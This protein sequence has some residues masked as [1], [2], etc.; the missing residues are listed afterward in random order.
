MITIQGEDI[1]IPD[2][3]GVGPEMKELG[4]RWDGRQNAWK[5]AAT[6]MNAQAVNELAIDQ[7]IAVPLKVPEVVTDTRLYDYQRDAANRLAAAPHGALACL[8]PGLGKTVVA[9]TAADA[10]YPTDQI[11]VVTLASLL[12]TWEREV[13]KWSTDPRVYVMTGKV[14]FDAATNARW[15]ICSWDKLVREAKTWGKGWRLFILDESVLTKSRSSKRFKTLAKLR[16]DID[17]VWL[18][19][20]SPT[21]RHSDDLWAQLNIIWPRAFPS[22]WRFAERYCVVE[23][24]PWARVVSGD[25][26]GRNAMEE[27]SDLVMV[28]NQEDV[29]DLPE[30]LYEPPLEVILTGPQHKAYREMEKTFITELSNGT[31]V[32]AQNEIARLMQLQ[33][34]ASFWDGHSAKR[35]A[36]LD[37]IDGYKPPFLIWTHWRETA[38]E[39]EYALLAHGLDAVAV[40]GDTKDKDARIEAYKAGGHDALVLS[41]GVGKFGHTLTNT[42][43]VVGFDRNFNA[44]DIFQAA[45]RVRRIGLTHSP[46]VLP[47]VAI[48]TVDELTVGDNLATKM[49]G[50]SKM[51]RSNLANLLKGLGR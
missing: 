28:V 35:D 9:I 45:H 4:A 49:A 19:S 26:R 46:V 17:K 11:V 41:L 25:R 50:I 47:I 29:L 13:T 33:R 14:D 51:T 21:S 22:Y 43:T 30:E 24:T 34:I 8:S 7:P 2:Q 37:V 38:T 3:P 44:D 6:R 18:L 36:L 10:A 5:L 15:I 42:R 40:T 27:N 12:R 20:G 23:E 1:L 32:I 39:L 31:E 48:G 16:R